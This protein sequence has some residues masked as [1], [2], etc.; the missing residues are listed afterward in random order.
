MSKRLF[1]IFFV[2]MAS[3]ARAQNTGLHYIK[4]V[5]VGEQILPVHPMNI[6][7]GEGAIPRDSVEL[8]NDTLH[9]ISV[10]TD[11]K[12]FAAMSSYLEHANF[13][14]KRTGHKIEF[15]TIDSDRL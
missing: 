6:S 13:K 12:S 14:L 2:A 1:F 3:C 11:Y 8:L 4:F 10:V 7:F 15:G 9:P 5:H